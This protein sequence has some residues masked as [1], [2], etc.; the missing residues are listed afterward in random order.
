M[1]DIPDFLDLNL[2]DF[3][4]RRSMKIDWMGQLNLSSMRFR[5]IFGIGLLIF[6]AS[7][8]GLLV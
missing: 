5:P 6:E 8:L 7:L 1:H 4:S 2:P 3:L